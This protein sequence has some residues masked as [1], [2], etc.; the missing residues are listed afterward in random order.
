[1]FKFIAG[2]ALGAAYG[3][4]FIEKFLIT[5]LGMM[6]SVIVV[7]FLGKKLRAWT[8]RKFRKKTKKKR[9]TKR[10]RRIVYLWRHYGEFGVS[11][12]TPLIFSPVIGTLLV[13]VLGGKRKKVIF[14][15]FISAVFWALTI[16][17]LSEVFLNAFKL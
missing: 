3:F 17:S 7:S 10:N 5:V 14:Y 13:M 9:F 4:S 1:M 16:T 6:T 15:M 12:F 2:P 8:Q 11:F